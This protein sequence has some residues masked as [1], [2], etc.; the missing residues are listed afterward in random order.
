MTWAHKY[1]ESVE[2]GVRVEGSEV[3]LNKVWSANL[4]KL[5]MGRGS[6]WSKRRH[7]CA[8]A[9]VS[10]EAPPPPDT[11]AAKT[12]HPPAQPPVSY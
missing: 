5:D 10:Q 8:R 1:R 9:C 4:R 2:S 12:Q 7:Q 6:S 3:A 11:G